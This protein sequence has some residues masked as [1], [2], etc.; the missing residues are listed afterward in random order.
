[1]TDWIYDLYVQEYLLKMNKESSHEPNASNA[2][3]SES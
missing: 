1:M 2:E 3:Q